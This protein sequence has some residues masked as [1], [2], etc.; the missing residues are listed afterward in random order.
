MK[1]GTTT[2]PFMFNFEM[3]LDTTKILRNLALCCTLG[4]MNVSASVI[5]HADT[6]LLLISLLQHFHIQLVILPLS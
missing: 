2:L 4:N 1:A 6:F 3:N 5:C